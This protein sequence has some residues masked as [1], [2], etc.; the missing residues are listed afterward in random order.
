V[1]EATDIRSEKHVLDYLDNGVVG[2]HW[3]SA[4]GTIVWANAADFEFLGYNRDE[5][6]GHHISEFHADVN[7]ITD[8][9]ERLRAGEV[10][11]NYQ[12]RLRCKDGSTRSVLIASNVL[13]DENGDFIHTRCFTTLDPAAPDLTG[14]WSL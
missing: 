13:F 4:D 9:V 1:S 10:V 2:L 3:C 12:A 7:V 8:I 14:G 5:Y 11:Y 6:V